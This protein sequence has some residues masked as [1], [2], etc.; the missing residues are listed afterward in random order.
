MIPSCKQAPWRWFSDRVNP[1]KSGYHEGGPHEAGPPRDSLH[2][3]DPLEATPT[4]ATLTKRAPHKQATLI[5]EALMKGTL[6]EVAF[7]R[8][9]SW[10][11]P[12]KRIVGMNGGRVGD[13][14]ISLQGPLIYGNPRLTL[15][16][17]EASAASVEEASY[18][19]LI[20]AS[21]H[22]SNSCSHNN[23][24]RISLL[25]SHGRPLPVGDILC[26]H[27]GDHH[28]KVYK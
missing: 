16:R 12:H 2:E 3:G 25:V 21:T 4:V 26:R 22:E 18:V 6:P 8:M 7:M 27:S 1:H 5:E 20:K 24:K 13:H 11:Q 10:K 15:Q 9:T 23:R 19:E 14:V 28:P 17:K